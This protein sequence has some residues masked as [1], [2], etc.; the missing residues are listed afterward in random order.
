MFDEVVHLCQPATEG[1][2]CAV[3]AYGTGSGKT[4][5]M[6][7]SSDDRYDG[8]MPRSAETL[9]EI[10][11]GQEM[12]KKAA[13]PN[14]EKRLA[15][16]KMKTSY[17]V[18]V[19]SRCCEHAVCYVMQLEAFARLLLFSRLLPFF[20]RKSFSSQ[21]SFFEIYNKNIFDLLNHDPSAR[22]TAL[23]MRTPANKAATWK[24]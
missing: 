14:L 6:M 7:G 19:C 22:D 24:G 11:D 4:F 20:R 9:F 1:F 10:L 18:K 2:A 12:A 16:R 15:E 3:F 17:T 21:A 8:V 23:R 5:T 13:D